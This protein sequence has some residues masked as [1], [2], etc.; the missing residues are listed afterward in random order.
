[1]KRTKVTGGAGSRRKGK[2]GELEVAKILQAEGW[3]GAK[4]GQQR[5]G[6]DQPDV[7]GGPVDLHLEVKRT[8]TVKLRA[9]MAQAVRDAPDGRIPTVVHRS[10]GDPT[11]TA[12][13]PFLALVRLLGR[14]E[15][16]ESA[17][18]EAQH[19]QRSSDRG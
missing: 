17:T 19:R 1:M 4:R 13:V 5:A 11:W 16:L 14:L 15:R 9:W 18:G 12:T 2:G 3:L 8:E 7:I 6:V 10:N